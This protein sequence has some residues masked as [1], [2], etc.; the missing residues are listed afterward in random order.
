MLEGNFSL[1]AAKMIITNADLASHC[2]H[3][4]RDWIHLGHLP[5]PF[6]TFVAFC[7]LSCT[8]ILLLKGVYSKRKSL[9]SLAFNT[10]G[11]IFSRRHFGIFFLFFPEN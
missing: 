10:V 11:K 4:L 6:T 3:V 7:L 5:H 2:I 8:S 1:D 9:A